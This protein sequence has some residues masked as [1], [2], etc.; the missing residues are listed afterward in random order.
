M[1]SRNQKKVIIY[2][3]DQNDL[4]D[5]I[6]TCKKERSKGNI[7]SLNSSFANLEELKLWSSRNEISEVI[8]FENNNINRSKI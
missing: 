8:F 1:K 6:D 4:N 3:D 5:A 2:I 7:V